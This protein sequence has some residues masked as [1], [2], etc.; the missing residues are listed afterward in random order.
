LEA[1]G[2]NSALMAVWNDEMDG[3]R[4]NGPEDSLIPFQDWLVN[5]F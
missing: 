2:D 4:E 3:Y 1:D 5:Y